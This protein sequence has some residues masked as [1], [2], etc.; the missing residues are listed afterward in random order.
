MMFSEF[1]LLDA[2]KDEQE[3]PPQ[4]LKEPEHVEDCCV[5][6]VIDEAPDITLDETI[7]DLG[8]ALELLQSVEVLFYL[9]PMTLIKE[10]MVAAEWWEVVKVEREIKKFLKQW[11]DVK[12]TV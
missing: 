4:P 5:M 12:E 11:A 10:H 6:Q 2:C 7:E 3:T 8:N 9:L 1:D